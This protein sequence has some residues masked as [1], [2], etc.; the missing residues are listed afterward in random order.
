[1][2]LDEIRTKSTEDMTPEEIAMLP[3]RDKALRGLIYDPCIYDANWFHSQGWQHPWIQKLMGWM[4]GE[5]GPFDSSL[6]LGAGDGYYS[7]V[8]AEMGAD[9]A[10]AVEV[11]EEA[12]GAMEE[13]VQGLVHD[14]R[15]PLDLG[16]GFDLIVC[17]EVA[18]HL[19]LESADVLCE[20][21]ARHCQRRLIF[22][23]APPGQ[24]GHGHCNLQP[25]KFWADRLRSRGVVFNPHDTVRVK[26]AWERI[27]GEHLP[28]L[29]H[30]IAMFERR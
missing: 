12:L 27:L 21:I 4:A 23:A 24:G 2:N 22:T 16:R 6:D 9:P 13:D 3:D 18:E 30:N 5:Y 28:W 14:L 19:P 1:M 11:S 20:S 15:E 8:L 26:I 17:L 10:V 29:F 7:H 25:F